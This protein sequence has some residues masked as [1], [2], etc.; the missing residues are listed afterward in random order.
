MKLPFFLVHL[1]LFLFIVIY[2]IKYF[3]QYNLN[4][5]YFVFSCYFHIVIYL[6]FEAYQNHFQVENF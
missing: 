5:L 1:I 3:S 6:F 4:Y 2:L